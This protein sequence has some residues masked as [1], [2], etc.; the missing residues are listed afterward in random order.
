MYHT[1]TLWASVFPSV[2]QDYGPS[3][4]GGQNSS[5]RGE[6]AQQRVWTESS[7]QEALTPL[8]CFR[9]CS[10]PSPA[11]HSLPSTSG[12]LHML[13]LLPGRLFSVSLCPLVVLGPVATSPGKLSLAPQMGLMCL[14][15]C[16]AN[17]MKAAWWLAG[18]LLC[19]LIN[20]RWMNE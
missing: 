2:T 8:A 17:S 5:M 7:P 4:Q 19:V 18:P 20:V 15:H 1:P 14:S 12:P 11:P 9:G 10:H 16:S 6:L 13:F 3:F